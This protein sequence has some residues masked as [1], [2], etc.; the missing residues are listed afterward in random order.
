MEINFLYKETLQDFG[1]QY[2]QLPIALKGAINNLNTQYKVAMRDPN[3]PDMDKIRQ[4]KIKDAEIADEIQ[5]W[6]ERDLEE[7]SET[8]KPNN[9]QN[10]QLA[11]R[12][13]AVGLPET[14][15]EAEIAAKEKQNAD[16][17][18]ADKAAAD[19]AAADKA[20]ADKAAASKASASGDF[21]EDELDF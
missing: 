3:N 7:E 13:K 6:A 18:A 5:T 12:A 11:A 4:V 15:T 14:A 16:K 2:G 10:E 1:L 20:A 21:F 17:A 8:P 9:M 19:K